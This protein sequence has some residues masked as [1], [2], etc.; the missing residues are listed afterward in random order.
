MATIGR[1]GFEGRFD[2]G[3]IGSVVNLAARLC[4]AAKSG[5]ILVSQRVHEAVA[6][7]VETE[8]LGD[9]RIKGLERSVRVF[10]VRHLRNGP[11]AS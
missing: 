1:I 3:A 7:R 6:D 9:L 4:A 11:I 10:N 8:P 5:E 2:Y